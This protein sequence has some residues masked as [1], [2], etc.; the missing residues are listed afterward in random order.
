MR[1]AVSRR[2]EICF[3]GY[4]CELK[5]SEWVLTRQ[6]KNFMVIT[7]NKKGFDD[8]SILNY[9]LSKGNYP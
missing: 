7:R 6:H 9:L 4:D 8:Y 2:K 1:Y 5:F 3:R